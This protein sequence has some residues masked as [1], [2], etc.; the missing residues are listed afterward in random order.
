[1]DTNSNIGSDEIT[2]TDSDWEISYPALSIK[3]HNTFTISTSSECSKKNN[4]ETILKSGG[5]THSKVLI[6]S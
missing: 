4:R 3:T 5:D 2:S 1:M 6:K